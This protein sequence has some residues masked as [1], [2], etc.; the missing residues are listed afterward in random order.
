M[1]KNLSESKRKCKIQPKSN[2]NP[3]I[4]SRNQAQ[5]Q[6]KPSQARCSQIKPGK[7]KPKP[8]QHRSLPSRGATTTHSDNDRNHNDDLNFIENG[9]YLL[10]SVSRCEHFCGITEEPASDP[11]SS[12]EEVFLFTQLL[13]QSKPF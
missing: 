10:N 3:A 11:R 4:L 12:V 7:I 2:Q 9:L 5:I 6:P 8:S 13:H 1:G